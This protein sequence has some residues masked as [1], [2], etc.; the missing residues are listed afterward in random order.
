MLTLAQLMD[1]VR[2]TI[3]VAEY[4]FIITHDGKGHANARL[5]QPFG[6]DEDLNIWFGTSA[7]SRKV[8]EI[9]KYENVALTFSHAGE[10]AYV[11]MKGTASVTSDAEIKQHYWRTS[12]FDFWPEGSQSEG[13][14]VI[15]FV[16]I[17]IEVMNFNK[18]IA[19]EPYDLK[20]AILS[21]AGA[22]WQIKYPKS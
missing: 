13:Y 17:H 7:G 5:M 15:K 16:P 21:R 11:T 14:P 8:Q 9:Q 4:C 1:V 20:P 3:E 2:H 12:F 6:P 19:P 10:S 22:D 18:K